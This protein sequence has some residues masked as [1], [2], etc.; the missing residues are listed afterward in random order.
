MLRWHILPLHAHRVSIFS[1]YLVYFHSLNLLFPGL[2]KPQALYFKKPPSFLSITLSPHSHYCSPFSLKH[3]PFICSL[4]LHNEERSCFR[5]R[6]QWGLLWS[7]LQAQAVLGQHPSSNHRTNPDRGNVCL[8]C[9]VAHAVL[10]T[11]VHG[12][13]DRVRQA[14]GEEEVHQVPAWCYQSGPGAEQELSQS[15]CSDSHVQWKRG[16]YQLFLQFIKDN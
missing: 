8:H 14:A 3:H 6:R 11:G 7:S 12:D 2:F 10:W 5:K 13:C 16:I 4:S 9:H 15:A 1:I